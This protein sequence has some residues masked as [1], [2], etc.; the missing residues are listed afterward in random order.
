[1]LFLI[2]DLEIALIYPWAV[3]Y[4]ISS[5]QGLIAIS[6]FIFILTV[7]FI[8]EWNKGALDWSSSKTPQVN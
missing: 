2:F 5:Y 7:G 6:Y 1:M 8:Y 4:K 3:N